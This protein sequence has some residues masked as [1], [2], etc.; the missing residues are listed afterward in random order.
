M[1]GNVR[2]V[3]FLKGFVGINF[4][5][6]RKPPSSHHSTLAHCSLA[7]VSQE[8]RLGVNAN[9]KTMM[10]GGGKNNAK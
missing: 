6:N 3:S 5:G 8:R 9:T 4:E 2:T 7:I 1:Y 10:C